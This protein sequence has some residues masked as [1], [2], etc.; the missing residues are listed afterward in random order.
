M[1]KYLG[2]AA[3]IERVDKDQ[4]MIYLQ[5]DRDDRIY[6][7]ATMGKRIAEFTNNLEPRRPSLDGAME[8][9]DGLVATI[10]RYYVEIPSPGE[11]VILTREQVRELA[12][13]SGF[14]VME[15]EYGTWD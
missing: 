2:A 13:S 12:E 5:G 10:H 15:A 3:W 9:T 6:L 4:C 1:K 14:L 7:D 11:R 8:M